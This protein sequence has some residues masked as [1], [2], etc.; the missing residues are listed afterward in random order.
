MQWPR[1]SNNNKNTTF[2]AQTPPH[3]TQTTDSLKFS[4]SFRLNHKLIALLLQQF[5]D[6]VSAAAERLQQR[7]TASNADVHRKMVA[8]VNRIT[9][10]VLINKKTHTQKRNFVLF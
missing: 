5:V 3:A 7:E 6:R 2:Y 9:V 1:N 10:V 4:E 8:R